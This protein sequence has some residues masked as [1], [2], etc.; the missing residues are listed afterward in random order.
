MS[1]LHGLLLV[2]KPS[3]VTSH[4]VVQKVRRSLSIKE[5]GHTGTLDPLAEGLMVLLLGEATKISSYVLEE[6]KQ[7]EVTLQ[8][9]VET[10][11]LDITGT[12]LKETPMLIEDSIVVSSALSLQGQFEWEVPLFSATK[13][14]GKKL[15]EYAREGSQEVK[16]PVKPM[17]FWGNEFLG[18]TDDRRYRFRLNCSKGS[19]IRSWVDRL[20]RTLGCGAVMTELT[21]TYSAPYPLSQALPLEEVVSIERD[22]KKNIL[23]EGTASFIPMLRTLPGFKVVRVSGQSEALIKNG[24]ISHELRRRLIVSF[25]PTKDQ[26]IKVLSQRPEELLALIGF[27]KEKG[28]VVRRVFRY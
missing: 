22:F 6:D 9:G 15:Y 24:Q 7:Y 21:R 12:I 17:S 8:T 19:F 26:G 13:V 25:D 16:V 20:G 2:R 4:D 27:D 1:H 3:G 10:D 23:L 28:F 11:T 18:K 5:V 14:D